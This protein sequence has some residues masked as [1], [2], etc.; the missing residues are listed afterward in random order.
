MEKLFEIFTINF[1]RK[2]AEVSKAERRRWAWHNQ[3][4]NL[5]N[6]LSWYHAFV[7]DLGL[8]AFSFNPVFSEQLH[9]CLIIQDS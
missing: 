2:F 4:W 3:G 7:D 6:F 5:I 9:M 1:P 8:S